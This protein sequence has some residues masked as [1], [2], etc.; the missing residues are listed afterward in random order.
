[1]STPFCK[2]CAHHQVIHHD[3]YGMRYICRAADT[4]RP[5]PVTGEMIWSSLS[6]WCEIAREEGSLCGPTGKLFYEKGVFRLRTLFR[7]MGL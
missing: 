5:H 7:W 3:Q 1:M 2:D 6:Q 4:K